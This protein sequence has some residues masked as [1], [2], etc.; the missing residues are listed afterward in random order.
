ML[1]T[2]ATERAA[3]TRKAKKK[4][5]KTDKIQLLCSKDKMWILKAI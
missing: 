5:K 3:G 2:S 4:G 1:K